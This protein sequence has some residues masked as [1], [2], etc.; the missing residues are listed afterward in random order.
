VAAQ[1]TLDTRTAPVTLLRAGA[2]VL[3][4]Y[5]YAIGSWFGDR[6]PEP[7]AT[8]REWLNRP[9]GLGED[10]GPFAVML[11]LLTTG[12]VA[13]RPVAVC[14][15]LLVSAV[16]AGVAALAGLPGAVPLAWVT[17]LQVVAWLLTFDKAGW[18]S[19]VVLLAAVGAAA[20]VA[21]PPLA[22]PLEFLPLVLVGFVTR[23]V[24]DRALPAWAGLLLGAGCAAAMLL[25]DDRFEGLDQCWYP[26]GAV[27]AVLLFLVSTRPG[28]TTD[29]LATQ[30]AVRVLGAAAEWLLL[31][32]PVVTFAVLGLVA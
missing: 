23:R 2:A 31:A 11:L 24:L 12:F 7:L 17:A 27:I 19:V 8:I 28:P 26:A 3:G 4:F 1:V 29:R 18:P 30:P 5:G 32:G 25:V 9:L 20:L 6:N 22:R 21:W 15:P 13:R 10:F 14:L 16:L